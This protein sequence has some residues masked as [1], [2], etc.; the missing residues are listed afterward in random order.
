LLAVDTNGRGSREFLLR[1]ADSSSA[2]QSGREFLKSQALA[3]RDAR[4][5]LAA[6]LEEAKASRREVWVTACGP[7]S[8]PC[9]QL[10][11]W[12]DDQQQ[13]LEFDYVFVPLLVGCDQHVDEVLR[14]LNRPPRETSLPWFAIVGKNGGPLVT[15]DGPR[16]NVGFPETGAAKRYL[17][18]MIDR[19][20]GTMTAAEIDRLIQSLGK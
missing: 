8:E 1:A 6:A 11:R 9:F 18:Q 16:G 19:T 15:S 2:V 5:L 17:R 4:Q 12:I 20:A 7:R 3:P 13:P 10:V 14:S